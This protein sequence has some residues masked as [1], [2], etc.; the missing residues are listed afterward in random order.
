M[1]QKKRERNKHKGQHQTG[2]VFLSVVGYATLIDEISQELKN[3][4][5]GVKSE[6]GEITAVDG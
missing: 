6:T 3:N 5:P 2:G 4:G 1:Q